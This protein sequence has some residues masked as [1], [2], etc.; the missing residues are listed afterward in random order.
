VLSK[1]TDDEPCN[2]VALLAALTVRV[3]IRV[4]APA[5]LLVKPLALELNPR[6]ELAVDVKSKLL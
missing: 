4:I 2:I 3:L 1:T 6:P 5:E